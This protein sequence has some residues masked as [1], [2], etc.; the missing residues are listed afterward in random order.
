MNFV[1]KIEIKVNFMTD[2]SFQD[3]LYDAS[4]GDSISLF[5]L[6]DGWLT[7]QYSLNRT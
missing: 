4:K 6:L 7:R 5:Q 1:T 3:L 2:Q